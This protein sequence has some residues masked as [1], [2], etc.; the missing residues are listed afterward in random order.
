MSVGLQTVRAIIETGSRQ[1]VRELRR[2]WF[3]EAELPAYDF[4]TGFYRRHGALPTRDAFQ[5]NGIN[6]RPV[7]NPVGYYIERLRSR[8]V[9]S[10]VQTNHQG[11]MEALTSRDPEA[12]RGIVSDIHG[13]IQ[14]LAIADDVANVQ[15]IAQ[16]VLEE[17]D[18]PDATGRIAG[19]DHGVSPAG[20]LHGGV[21]GWRRVHHRRQART[22][23]KLRNHPHG[24]GGMAGGAQ[25]RVCDH[26]D[27]GGA[28]YPPCAGDAERCA[29]RPGNVHSAGGWEDVL[30]G[31]KRCSG[32]S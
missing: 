19:G 32:A 8:A 4:L 26:G 18:R 13:S 29:L 1:S 24:G 2:E 6:L 14:S 15:T 28:D 11:L 20:H 10:A 12:I 5:E 16:I 23:E 3:E 22:W 30:A 21:D 27:D 31:M 9:Y 7:N 17:L 25:R